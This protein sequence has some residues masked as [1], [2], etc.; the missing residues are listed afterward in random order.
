VFE[1]R[2]DCEDYEKRLRGERKE[3][4]HCH[5]KGYFSQGWHQVFNEMAVRYES[6][7]YTETCKH[8]NGKGYL[9]K[10]EVWG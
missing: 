1:Y 6:V 10:K 8:C 9:E 3:C 4:P 7:E 5:G 2:S